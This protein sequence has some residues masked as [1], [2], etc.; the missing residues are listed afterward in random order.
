MPYIHV[1]TAQNCKFTKGTFRI[2][3]GME[4]FFEYGKYIEVP[5]GE[6]IVQVGNESNQWTIRET[7]G[8]NDDLEVILYV[9][10]SGDSICAPEYYV[11]RDM[12]AQTIGIIKERIEEAK[13]NEKRAFDKIK[14]IIRSIAAIMMLMVGLSMFTMA[15]LNPDMLGLI[16]CGVGVVF[17]VAGIILIISCILM[18]KKQK[19]Q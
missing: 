15:I 11:K 1:R 14:M 6:H 18:K 13:E 9:D 17:W 12:D 7:L 19:K 8:K 3:G 4:E 10:G 5:V 2:D 16:I